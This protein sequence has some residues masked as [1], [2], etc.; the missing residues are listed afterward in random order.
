MTLRLLALDLSLAG[1]GIAWTHDWRGQP[2]LGCS[3]VHTR[4]NVPAG[5]D[6]Q[7]IHDVYVALKA[8]AKMRPQVVVI[9]WLP[10]M[11]GHGEQ[12]LRLAELHGVIKHWLWAAGTP[13]AEVRP[14]YLQ[15]FATGKGR[16]T[17]TEVRA[18]ITARVGRLV[19]IGTTDEA[20]AVTLLA[21]GLAHYGQPLAPVSESGR[22]ALEGVTWPQ[23]DSP[24][25]GAAVRPP[26]VGAPGRIA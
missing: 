18:G 24:T 6:H 4:R 21:M 16:A 2:G 20:D 5:I 22:R 3:T 25:A 19:H 8:A 13:Y 1:T 12:S 9:E 23:I 14:T 26:A 7:R 11:D 17:K 15:M 10:Q